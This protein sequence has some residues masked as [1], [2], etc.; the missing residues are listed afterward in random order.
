MQDEFKPN[1]SGGGQVFFATG[2]FIP[3]NI[4]TGN[5]AF[6]KYRAD[7]L[8]R[9]DDEQ[10]KFYQFRE[11]LLEAKDMA[12]FEQFMADLKK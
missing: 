8:A 4:G 3:R 10:K 12:E 6:D 7:T 1:Y 11:K 2:D 5:R 9:L